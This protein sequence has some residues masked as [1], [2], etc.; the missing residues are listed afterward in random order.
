MMAA[1]TKGNKTR[2][3]MEGRE[4][5][6]E[7]VS[8]WRP[9]RNGLFSVYTHFPEVARIGTD[10]HWM[11]A[12]CKMNHKV[13]KKESDEIRPHDFKC[14]A[15]NQIGEF[16][17]EVSEFIPYVVC[18]ILLYIFAMLFW[19][20]P[21]FRDSHHVFVD[22]FLLKKKFPKLFD[23][24]AD[25]EQQ[26]AFYEDRYRESLSEAEAASEGELQTSSRFL[27]S[28]KLRFP[29]RYNPL[30]VETLPA[31]VIED[32]S[33]FFSST[34]HGGPLEQTPEVDTAAAAA[35]TSLQNK[36]RATLCSTVATASPDTTTSGGPSEDDALT[37]PDSI[38]NKSITSTDEENLKRS[39]PPL[40]PTCSSSTRAGATNSTDT[41]VN[42]AGSTTSTA[43]SRSCPGA[44]GSSSFP[45]GA[46]ACSS[47]SS[48]KTSVC[49]YNTTSSLVALEEDKEL[50]KLPELP[51]LPS[52]MQAVEKV[53]VFKN[54]NKDHTLDIKEHAEF[55]GDAVPIFVKPKRGA[56]GE[57]CHI[58]DLRSVVHKVYE[59]KAKS[60]CRSSTGGAGRDSSCTSSSSSS[61]SSRS[62]SLAPSQGA[63]PDS[64]S[65]TCDHEWTK[66]RVEFLLFE[67]LLTNA[68]PF[69]Q[70]MKAGGIINS[71]AHPLVTLRI[72]TKRF[73]EDKNDYV[74]ALLVGPEDEEISNSKKNSCYKVVKMPSEQVVA[75][76]AEENSTKVRYGVRKS[77][78]H[79]WVEIPDFAEILRTCEWAA[80][81]TPE[82]PML[83]SDFAV[84]ADG[85]YLL[86]VNPM[87]SYTRY[88]HVLGHF[89]TEEEVDLYVRRQ[90]L[91]S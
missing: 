24:M 67:E 59:A 25:K 32:T 22:M 56:Y 27:P 90:N 78:K 21:A 46:S 49:N 55:D 77:K 53:P 50:G 41:V 30:N 2:N 12:Y 61:S 33:I 83:G 26:Q 87:C 39:S 17:A 28:L 81:Q 88:A 20:S 23:M 38:E 42:S 68:K 80:D 84:C 65:W 72:W 79:P 70:A 75:Q 89:Y 43:S 74:A 60:G 11:P 5:Q 36:S 34:A 3:T 13:G 82:L 48:S 76:D 54:C 19:K 58:R 69:Q 10:Y 63:E 8:F 31:Q 6:E 45:A 62:S 18:E 85:F 15:T 4:L 91:S 57:D 86:E 73:H 52:A 66:K 29:R 47:T 71:L 1:A 51:R 16:A 14:M 9:S 44:S 40:S 35:T 37:D 64:S 7:P